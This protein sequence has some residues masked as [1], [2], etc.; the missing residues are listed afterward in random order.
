MNSRRIATT[1][2]SG[3]RALACFALAFAVTGNL[4]A[5][6]LLVN[7]SFDFDLTGWVTE[8]EDIDVTFQNDLGSTLPGGS[9]P[10][11]LKIQGLYWDGGS[12]GPYQDVEGITEG[13]SFTVAGSVFIP[14]GENSMVGSAVIVTWW[15]ESGFFISDSWIYLND[16]DA[17]IWHRVSGTVVAPGHA[18]KAQVRLTIDQPNDPDETRP[19]IVVWDDVLFVEEG[20]DEAVQSL[21]V[22]AAASVEGA[23]GTIW[24]TAVWVS[25]IV[26]V[27]ITLYAAFLP[28]GEDNTPR[29]SSPTELITLP[30]GGFVELRDIVGALGESE[31]A[32]GLYLEARAQ[33]GGL[34]ATLMAVTTYT[35]TPNPSGDGNYGQGLP[36]VGPGTNNHVFVPGL[37]QGSGRRTNIGV[38]NTSDRLVSVRVEILDAAGVEL[39]QEIW[40]LPPFSHK[41]E[42][43]RNLGI[44]NLDGGTVV[45]TRDSSEGSFRAYTSTIDQRTGDAVYNPGL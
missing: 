4:S 11:A 37:F 41:Q 44:S 18:A 34:P 30:A 28:E 29:T 5:Q 20:I 45:M 23:G 33:A 10:G 38:L 17:D 39:T 9:G 31:V 13:T 42:S 16:M 21:F 12:I 6:N 15:D 27:P 24:S 35:F 43:L 1:F 32:G 3:T 7:A 25:N 8:I 2:L 14:S 36:G 26:D 40:R 22:P 19:G